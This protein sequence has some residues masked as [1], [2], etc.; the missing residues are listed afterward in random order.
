MVTSNPTKPHDDEAQFGVS[1]RTLEERLG[2]DLVRVVLPTVTTNPV[3]RAIDIYDATGDNVGGD[4]VLLSLISVDAMR[5]EEIVRA[6]ASAA[7]HNCSGVAVKLASSSR[8]E[9]ALLDLSAAAGLAVVVL[10]A[11]LSWR[12]FDA[13][14]TRALG[15]SGRSL[16]LAPSTGDKLFAIANTIAR[17]FAGSVTIEDHQR[18]ILAH[19]SVSGQAI[20]ELRTTGILFR[21]AGDGPIHARRYREALE[22]EGIVWFPRDGDSLPRAVVAIWAGNIPLGTIW[23]L[24]PE[25]D[26]SG[27]SF[28]DSEKARALELG[29]TLAAGALMEAWQS[30]SRAGS[31]RASALKRVLA[32]TTQPGDQEELDPTGDGVGVV[33]VAE[34]AAGPRAAGRMAEVRSALSRHLSVFVPSIAFIAE[35]EEFIALCPTPLTEQVREWVMSAS[36][37]LSA[38]TIEG[39]SFGVSDPHALADRITF[40]AAEA[41]NLA[42]HAQRAGEAVGTVSRLRTQLFLAACRAQL[43]TDDRLL[44]PEVREL[45]DGGERGEQLIATLECWLAEAGNVA[46]TAKRLRVHEQTVR[47]RIRRLRE[48]VP[49]DTGGPDY[50]LTLWAQLRAMR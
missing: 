10:T 23:A 39:L 1:L 20:D 9:T 17:V 7:A 19:S 41:R 25:G 31:R 26:E 24:D 14:V 8:E 21:S 49:L 12:E 18:G 3:V 2:S 33:L 47:Y 22:A 50:L 48:R 30:N 43:E 32:S 34:V 45:F 5:P 44:L 4:G 27:H 16:A 36:A 46:R 42:L 35:G 28:H 38:D 11:D 37:E 13:L 29:A 40:A 15:E 6:L